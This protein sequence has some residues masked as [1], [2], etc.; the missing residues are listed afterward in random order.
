MPEEIKYNKEHLS[1]AEHYM[2][3][4]HEYTPEIPKEAEKVEVKDD[5]KDIKDE[6][7]DIYIMGKFKDYLNE[8]KIDGKKTLEA[9]Q[10][11]VKDSQYEKIQGQNVD[12]IT[13]N[14]LLKVYDAI[15]KPEMKSKFMSTPIKKMVSIAWSLTK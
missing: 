8:A 10:R 13:A 11:I 15:K 7:E 14:L 9:L 5:N 1:V 3:T 6:K 2:T 4:G 12:G